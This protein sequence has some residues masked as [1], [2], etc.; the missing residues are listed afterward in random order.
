MTDYCGEPI[1]PVAGTSEPDDVPG[2]CNARLYIADNFGD[3]H[4]TMRCQLPKGHEGRHREEYV[5]SRNEV[6]VTWEK[7]GRR[8]NDS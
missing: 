4:A 2:D 7:D 6:T 3:N 1:N 5:V 8:A